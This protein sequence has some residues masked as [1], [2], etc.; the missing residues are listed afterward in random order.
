LKIGKQPT[1]EYNSPI[2]PHGK[3]NIIESQ[4]KTPIGI[5]TNQNN[6]SE[7]SNKKRFFENTEIFQ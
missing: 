7:Q 4:K 6:D 2:S 3:K 5:S 1:L